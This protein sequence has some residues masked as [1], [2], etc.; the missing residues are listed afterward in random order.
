M[1]RSSWLAAAFIAASACVITPRPTLADPVAA[2]PPAPT[3]ISA[4]VIVLHAINDSSGIDPAIGSM[5][6]LLKPPFSSYNSYKL[7][8]RN[9]L[10]LP[11]GVAA[12]LKLP[13]GRELHVVYKDLVPPVKQSSVARFL[14]AAS[15]QKPNGKDFLPLVEVNA[16]PGEWFWVGGQEYK[17]GA[18]FIGIKIAP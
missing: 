4:E 14:V 13:T 12:P 9:S 15:I 3:A 2:M 18:V 11:R 16:T 17:G 7:L 1:T 6:A 8:S 10:R 5:P